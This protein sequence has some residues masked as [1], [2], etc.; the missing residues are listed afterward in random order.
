M[1]R[2][3]CTTDVLPCSQCP[4][5]VERNAGQEPMQ[6][7]PCTTDVLPCSQCPVGVERNAGQ[8]SEPSNTSY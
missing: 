4:V 7:S 8:E 1:Q 2:S 6:R 5:G 3:P